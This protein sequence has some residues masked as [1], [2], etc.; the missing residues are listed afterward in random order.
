MRSKTYNH[1]PDNAA[2]RKSIPLATGLLDYFPKALIS[3]ASL[4][5]VGNEQHN[6]GKP[7]HWD[8]SKSTDHDDC[9]M[10][11]FIDRGTLDTDGVRHRTKVA[12]RALAALQVEI[13][14][15]INAEGEYMRNAGKPMHAYDAKRL[16]DAKQA[17]DESQDRNTDWTELMASFGVLQSQFDAFRKKFADMYLK[18]NGMVANP[19]PVHT[20]TTKTQHPMMAEAL[21]VEDEKL[22]GPEARL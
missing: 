7:M 13:E 8:R 16:Y 17:I 18:S 19:L 14:Q 1:L 20:T 12:W 21:R 9:L 3:V 11:H 22:H 6:P 4:S 10:R 2:S 15:S 5:F